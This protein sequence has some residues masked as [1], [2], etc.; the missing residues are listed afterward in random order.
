MKPVELM[1]RAIENSSKGR[2]IVL[3]PF[4]GSGSTMIACEKNGRQARLIE[5]DPR[6]VDTAVMRWQEFTGVEAVLDG[7]GR[8]FS[9]IAEERVAAKT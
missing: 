7:D 1:A 4:A 6:Y 9:E 2:D 8:C 5:L 3:D